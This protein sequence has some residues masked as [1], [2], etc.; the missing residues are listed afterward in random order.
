M[1]HAEYDPVRT[2]L[3]GAVA[4]LATCVVYPVLI[5]S[6]PPQ[7]LVVVLAAAMG[8]LLGI[9]S[10]GLREFLNLHQPRLSADLG[11]FS[12]GIAGALLTAMF[13]VQLASHVQT[14]GKPSR[15]AAAVWLGLDVA[16]DVY[17]GLGTLFFAV[18]A[19]RHP[20]LGRFIGVLGCA[21]AVALL[22]LNLYSFPTPP[23]NASLVDLGPLVGFWY[24]V[25]T[26][27]MLRSI[28]WARDVSAPAEGQP[29]RSF[30]E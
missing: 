2:V 15:E 1:R 10:W 25:V 22:C 23:A 8:P 21:I 14:A 29:G 6:R 30:T 18:A 4:G 5:V 11:A 3:V 9:A 7:L 27:G 16:W 13:L 17:V 26:V 24:L 12:N 28:R 20:R 19:F